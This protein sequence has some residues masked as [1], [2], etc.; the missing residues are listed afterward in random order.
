MPSDSE[1]PFYFGEVIGSALSYHRPSCHIVEQIRRRNYKRLRNWEEAVSLGLHPCP[2]CRPPFIRKPEPDKPTFIPKPE[3]G[4]TAPQEAKSNLT[5]S[6]LADLRRGLLR[7][8]DELGPRLAD[9]NLAQRIQR[10]SRSNDV[11]RNVATC[12]H[13]IR[14]LRNVS[15][16]EAKT[17]SL[18]E[19]QI[20]EG[21]VR[22][23]REWAHER[24]ITLP[25]AFKATG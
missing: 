24:G 7:L 2:H 9:E 22:V 23:I 25:D 1:V 3:P 15:E 5:S 6:Q 12:M 14:E 20:I 10:M 19:I 8:L 4:E 13:V 18:A 11:P 21:A 16:Y 17:T